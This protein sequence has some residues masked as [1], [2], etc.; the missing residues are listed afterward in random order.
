M[1]RHSKSLNY[2]PPRRSIRIKHPKFIGGRSLTFVKNKPNIE[3]TEL[4]GGG[5]L[6]SAVGTSN[7]L[8]GDEGEVDGSERGEGGGA[9]VADGFEVLDGDAFVVLGATGE[10]PTVG[11]AEGGEGG[12]GPLGELG[13]DGVEMGIKED[14][15]EGRVGTGPG[16][17]EEGLRGCELKGLGLEANGE[18]LGSEEGDGRSVIWVGMCGSN[19]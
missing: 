12:V 14:G 1:P 2:E 4:F 17:E 9:E 10:D 18:S 8:I 7:F 6:G 16:D 19:L 3:I 11:M 13:G 15:G 5:E